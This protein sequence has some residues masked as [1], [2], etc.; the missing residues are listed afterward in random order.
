MLTRTEDDELEL[1]H[2]FMVVWRRRAIVIITVLVFVGL[3]VIYDFVAKPVYRAST[4]V[5]LQGNLAESI[6][7]PDTTAQ[8]TASV[9]KTRVSTEMEVIQSKS[10]QAAAEKTLGET[11]DV[12][13]SQ[14]GDSDVVTISANGTDADKAAKIAQTYAETYISTRRAQLTQNYSDASTQLQL[15]VDDLNRQAADLQAPLDALDA[16]INAT[17]STQQKAALQAQRDATAKD[18]SDQRSKIDA[19]QST[20]SAQLDQLRLASSV[21]LTGGA[22]I[23]SAADAPKKP[24]SPDPVRNGLI[25]LFG[26][27]VVGLALAFIVDHADDR[28]KDKDDLESATHGLPTLGLIPSVQ[29][30]RDS[31]APVLATVVA[32]ESPASEAYRTLRTSLQFIALE[33]TATVVLFTSP[34]LGDGKTT[35]IA[36]VGVA[37]AR[38]GQRVVIVDCDLRRPRVHRFFAHDNQ[39]GFTS[40]LLRDVVLGEAVHRVEGEPRLAILPS[41]PPPPNP[42]EMLSSKRAADIIAALR[43]EADYVLIDAPPVLPVSDSLILAGRVDAVVLVASAGSSTTPLVRRAIEMLTQVDAPLVGTALNRAD[44][45]DVYGYRYG[46]QYGQRGHLEQRRRWPFGRRE[47]EPDITLPTESPDDQSAPTKV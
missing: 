2:Y 26:G 25:A 17:T 23:I 44:A 20:A 1:R 43:E 13:V 6:L 33:R 29:G 46:Y 10:V 36:N 27:L 32:P 5:L 24:V 41:G 39:V 37:L 4:D 21:A 15:L 22:Q 16:Q 42:S 7:S 8:N 47:R 31:N 14:S 30:W 38:A 28:I 35:T 11:V 18:V 9:D 34:S 12:S 19:R 40:V 45:A 3:S